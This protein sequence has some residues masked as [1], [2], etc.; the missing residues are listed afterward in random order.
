M[1]A[2]LIVALLAALAQ[3]TAAAE[4]DKNFHAAL[5]GRY[6]DKLRESPE[7]YLQFVKRMQPVYGFRYTDFAPENKGD[8]V[9]ADCKVSP[10][11]VAAVHRELKAENR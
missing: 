8:P 4:P 9:N 11:R 7:A 2:L 1:K 6:C 3:N 10:E 5:Y